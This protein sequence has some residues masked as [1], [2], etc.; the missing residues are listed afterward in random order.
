MD[1][2]E[3]R[4][5]E[6]NSERE[7]ISAYVLIAGLILEFVA[8]VL[9]FKGVETVVG[10]VAVAMIVGGVWGEVYFGKKASDAG[11]KQL[12]KYKARAAEAELALAQLEERLAPR[13]MTQ[14][15]QKL[16]ADRILPF[17]GIMG[18]IGTSP[19]EIE[20][21]RLESAI[22]GALSMG[23]WD[24]Q[25]GQPTHTPVWP[26]GVN[27]SMTRH[28]PSLAAGIALAEALNEVGIY[29]IPMPVLDGDSPRIFVTV[30]TKPDP[31]PDSADTHRIIRGLKEMIGEAVAARF[32]SEHGGK[33]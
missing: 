23:R 33:I 3:E 26:G 16:I 4:E 1:D 29:A 25:R 6:V 28:G 24:I 8:A 20:S 19:P 13:K 27:I 17:A 5:K 30:G 31:V 7:H 12:A 18:E 15:G 21:M 32:A 22:H 2:E 9:W 11:D 14:E 10:M